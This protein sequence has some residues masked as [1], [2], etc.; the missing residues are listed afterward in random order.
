MN[1]SNPLVPGAQTSEHAA[2]QQS[3][4][5]SKVLLVLGIVSTVAGGIVAGVQEYAAQ[6]AQAAGEAYVAN[7]ILAMILSIGGIVLAV[8][9]GVKK[10]LET[11]AY[12]QGRS[13]IKAAAAS[14]PKE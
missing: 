8:V 2:L 10:S 7:P 4:F 14:A 1:E 13:E 5:F 12:I 6:A 11:S 3:D 9:A